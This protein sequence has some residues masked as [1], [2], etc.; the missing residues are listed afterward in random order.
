M[1][2][3]TDALEREVAAIRTIPQD[4][5]ARMAQRRDR[6]CARI[7]Q[8]IAPRVRHF[9]RVYGLLDMADD[10]EQACAIGVHRAICDYDPAPCAIHH[11]RE[12]ATALR[13]A[14]LAPSRSAR[15]A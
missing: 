7:M 15:F 10:A 12:L 3:T 5:N 11:V 14:G 6:H 2:V 1:S 13:A 8:L 9:T 4:R